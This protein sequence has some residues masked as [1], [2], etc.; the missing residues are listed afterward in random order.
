M[1][2]IE[3]LLKEGDLPMREVKDLFIGTDV[4]PFLRHLGVFE[5]ASELGVPA[6]LLSPE[7]IAKRLDL[8]Q[9]RNG[10]K[11]GSQL[12]LLKSRSGCQGCLYVF[13]NREICIY[14]LVQHCLA[15]LSR[16]CCRLHYY[17]IYAAD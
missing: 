14:S 7:S 17:L 16:L 13:E 4:V 2:S 11:F 3:A 8:M 9:L 12:K 5:M 15:V 6:T 1:D 10:M